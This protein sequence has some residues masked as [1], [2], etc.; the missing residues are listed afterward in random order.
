VWAAI[1]GNLASIA[2]FGDALIAAATIEEVRC[3][4][5]PATMTMKLSWWMMMND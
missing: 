4:N 5:I 2:H 3:A 1:K